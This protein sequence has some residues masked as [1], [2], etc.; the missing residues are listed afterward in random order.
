MH[1]GRIGSKIMAVSD[2][3]EYLNAFN[4]ASRVTEFSVSSATVELASIA[5]SCEPARI[6]KTLSFSSKDAQ[7]CQLILTAGDARIDNTRFKAQFGNKAKM[8]DIGQVEQFTG[9]PVGGVCPFALADPEHVDVYIDVSL[10]RFNTVFPAA[11]SSS[12]AVELTC[13]ELYLASGAKGWIDV[14]KDWQ[15]T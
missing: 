2:V 3:K 15:P 12:S 4:L 13:K 9:H 8:L 10:Q 1:G 6:A 5:V 11:G 14:C 7:R